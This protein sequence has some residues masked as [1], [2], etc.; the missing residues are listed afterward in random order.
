MPGMRCHTVHTA[1]RPLLCASA[2]EHA[3]HSSRLQSALD[4]E[5]R[6]TTSND[7]RSVAEIGHLKGQH[8]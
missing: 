4:L 6:R 5:Q 1:C 8:A 7:H 3:M 2:R